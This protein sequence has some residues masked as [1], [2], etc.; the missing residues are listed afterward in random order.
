M[1]S[2]TSWVSRNFRFPFTKSGSGKA[3]VT[4]FSIRD[5]YAR[6]TFL[7]LGDT[8]ALLSLSVSFAAVSVSRRDMWGLKRSLR[9]R[10]AS[11]DELIGNQV[12]EHEVLIGCQVLLD[13]GWGCHSYV[14]VYFE[15]LACMQLSQLTLRRHS[16]RPIRKVNKQGSRKWLDVPC[17]PMISPT[18]RR[19]QPQ[20]KLQLT[21]LTLIH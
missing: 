14:S 19:H 15:Q 16:A 8:R 21:S 10:E 5:H 4:A 3:H 18:R 12:E 13:R 20:S 7:L 2:L 1:W 17:T 11:V 9:A 6:S